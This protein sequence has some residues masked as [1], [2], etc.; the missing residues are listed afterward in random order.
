M[1]LIGN[2]GGDEAT[3]HPSFAALRLITLILR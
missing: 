3:L 1:A 2:A